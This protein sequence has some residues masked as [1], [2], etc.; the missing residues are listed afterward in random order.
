MAV[1]GRSKQDGPGRPASN[2]PPVR[3]QTAQVEQS[4]LGP[5][6]ERKWEDAWR[7]ARA[8]DYNNR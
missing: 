7:R 3:Y 4:R 6:L 2:M 1:L 5:A 8:A